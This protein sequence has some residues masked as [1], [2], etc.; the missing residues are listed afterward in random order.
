[1]K[2][3]SEMSV[4]E[5]RVYA[6]ENS[7]TISRTMKR[8]DIFELVKAHGALVGAVPEDNVRTKGDMPSLAGSGPRVVPDDDRDAI[9]LQAQKFIQEK[10][11]SVRGYWTVLFAWNEENWKG[12]KSLCLL[13][14]EITTVM[15]RATGKKSE[16]FDNV[17][18]VR[19]R[20]N[21]G[22]H[23]S[24]KDVAT[25]KYVTSHRYARDAETGETTQRT[26]RSERKAS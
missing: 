15:Q 13:D 24:K 14:A 10:A 20:N 26:L 21:R 17:S 23:V 9:L 1:M 8:I 18:L 12:D 16:V 19:A 6:R 11:N 22:A 2:D 5:M 4:K 3:F 7:I 25:H